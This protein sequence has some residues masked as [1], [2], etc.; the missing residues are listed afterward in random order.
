MDLQ[1]HP[2]R[3]VHGRELSELDETLMGELE[4]LGPF[5]MG[6]PKPILV[7]RNVEPLA[8]PKLLKEKHLQLDLKQDSSVC[9]AIWFNSAANA[10]P[11]PPWDVA[12]ELVRNTFR[13]VTN[14][15]LQIR[16][17]RAT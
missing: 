16:R 14:L 8:K 17:I 11:N 9:R 12:F 10:L 6:N 1:S 13:G 5:G 4:K 3:I 2:L 7:A 15:Q